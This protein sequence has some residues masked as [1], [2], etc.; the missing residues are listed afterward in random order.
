MEDVTWKLCLM[1]HVWMK[2]Q[3]GPSGSGP[4]LFVC[5]S[6]SAVT[7]SHPG[8][9]VIVLLEALLFVVLNPF[10]F[11]IVLPDDGVMN[12][13]DEIEGTSLDGVGDRDIG[14]ENRPSPARLESA[15][16][17]DVNHDVG[18]P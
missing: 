2:F 14:G 16:G 4:R 9:G 15:P 3:R 12:S 17:N 8:G 10:N 5:N 6:S 13:E 18:S 7:D 1:H 11:D